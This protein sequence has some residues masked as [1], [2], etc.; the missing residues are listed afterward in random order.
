MLL[1]F[2]ATAVLTA[3]VACQ[4]VGKTLNILADW[5][6]EGDPGSCVGAPASR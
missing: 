4:F 2:N 1:C 3:A 5:V 6:R